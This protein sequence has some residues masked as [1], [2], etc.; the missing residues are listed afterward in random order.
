MTA[1]IGILNKNG[2]VLA[3]DSA[4]TLSDGKNSKV[5][6]S[7]RKLFT[8]S[9]EHSVGIMIYGN[10]SFME[11]PWEV[12][13]NEFKQDIGTDLLDNTAQY[14][15]KLIDF[16]I[17]FKHVQVEEL[18]INYIV[19][20]TRSILDSIAYEAQ[21]T[22]DLRVSNGETITQDDFNKILLDS[23][24]N[25]SLEV[26]KIETENNFE[27]FEAELELIKSI[28][29]DFFKS[30]PHTDD[31]VDVIAKSLYMAIFIGYDSTNVTG[32]VIAGYGT[33]EIFPS[34]RQI[35]LYGI[36]SKRLIWK[37]INESEINH[38]K[39]CHI[40]P[41]AQSEMVETIMNG[42]DPTLNVYI[43]EKVSSVME[44]RGL[45]S[46]IE[47][48]FEKI[49]EIQQKYYMN[50]IIDLIGM[51]PL[52]EMASTAKTFIELTSFKRK[53]VNTLETVGGPVD[54]L[55]IS[56]GEGPIWIDRKYY[57]DIDKNLDYRMRKES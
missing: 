19:R 21:E 49:S 17:S 25:F 30:F 24:N 41:F 36:F 40:I 4:V 12:I 29:D 13:L 35:E 46:E 1:E 47:E 56:K 52:N 16:L 6:N 44:K 23:I 57:F 37:V 26:S 11:I 8:L 27:F 50:P 3:S 10:A 39:S 18:L 22:A 5:F 15:E 14:V 2:V 31:E 48:I 33:E 51:Q 9:K 7:A 34:I 43:A 38:H 32:L 53:I 45:D 55:A 28:V 42:I 54:V 20:S